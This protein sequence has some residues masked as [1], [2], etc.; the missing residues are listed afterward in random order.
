M[1]CV[2][3]SSE[4]I[5]CSTSA[6]FGSLCGDRQSSEVLFLFIILHGSSTGPIA[7]MILIIILSNSSPCNP[8]F[9]HV[10][11]DLLPLQSNL[12][13]LPQPPST[14][15]RGSHHQPETGPKNSTVSRHQSLRRCL[16]GICRILR[17]SSRN[18]SKG[19]QSDGRA[20]LRDGV[21]YCTSEAL[22]LWAE[23]IGNDQVCDREDYCREKSACYGR[24]GT[25]VGVVTVR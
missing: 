7:L 9:F 17:N 18:D 19:C 8:L 2:R 6:T 5:S 13:H 10:G 15:P 12:A 23:G 3:R 4:P 11:P 21:E 14:N 16:I 1:S 24:K 25:Q 20:E 22:G